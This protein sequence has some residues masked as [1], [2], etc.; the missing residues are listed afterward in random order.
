[1]RIRKETGPWSWLTFFKVAGITAAMVSIFL[2]LVLI[3]DGKVSLSGWVNLVFYPLL[4]GSMHTQNFR[5]TRLYV[6]DYRHVSGFRELLLDKF[7]REGY[8]VCEIDQ[9]TTLLPARG[10]RRFVHRWFGT[11]EISIRWE[12]EIIISGMAQRI[13]WVEDILTWNPAFRYAL[14]TN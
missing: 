7:K 13:S 3:A 6:N 4:F 9:T 10:M 1:M 2:A 11:E 14:S 5:P 8:G 12:D